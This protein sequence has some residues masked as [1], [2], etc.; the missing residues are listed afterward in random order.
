MRAWTLPALLL[1]ITGGLAG[2]ID[3][4]SDQGV[5]PTDDLPVDIDPYKA[6]R[7]LVADLPCTVETVGEDPTQNLLQVSNLSNE[8]GRHAELDFYDD[9]MLWARYG[10]GGFEVLDIRDP[11]NVTLVGQYVEPGGAL[12]VKFSPDGT[13][14]FVGH[15]GGVEI[16]DMRVPAEPV[17]TG[18]WGFPP[19]KPG[20]ATRNA[21]ML[22][23]AHIADE[24]WL[25]IAPNANSGVY[26]VRIV[27]EP[28]EVRLEMV[29]QTLPVEGN[30]IGP[31]DMTV[32]YDEREERWILY[33]ADGFEGWSAFDVDDP[34]NPELIA[35]V[36]NVEPYQ[37]YTH[38][39]QATWVDDR[40]LVATIAEVGHNALK[41]YDATN[42]QLPVLLGTWQAG[43]AGDPAAPQHNLHVVGDLLYVAHYAR[44]FYVF[45]LTDV[46]TLPYLGFAQLEPMA[47][48]T[49]NTDVNQGPV[50]FDGVWEVVA[51]DGVLYAS[52]VNQLRV[53]GFGCVTP[54]DETHTSFG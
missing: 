26:I 36:P 51:K 53:F 2:C 38:T 11:L 48:W 14:A 13:T 1:F 24:D 22:A 18:F 16:A 25:F 42:L 33:V 29:A 4:S 27:G 40:R 52:D 15:G 7:N 47:H 19:A 37:G 35:R 28:G 9:I 32:Q 3:A 17:K 21:H 20:E 43:T 30:V 31:H 6:I 23:T 49:R 5:Q 41:I 12:D 39:I 34:A 8:E 50:G 54:G 46:P 45:N 44:G 10:A